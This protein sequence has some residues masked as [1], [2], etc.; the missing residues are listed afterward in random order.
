MVVS[1]VLILS[2]ILG[3]NRAIIKNCSTNPPIAAPRHGIFFKMA[4]CMKRFLPK[5]DILDDIVYSMPVAP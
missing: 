4:V 1:P 5:L 2:I 3:T